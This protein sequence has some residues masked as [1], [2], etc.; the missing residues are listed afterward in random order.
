MKSAFEFGAQR[1]RGRRSERHL[2]LLEKMQHAILQHFGI[3]RKVLELALFQ[4][5]H[6]GVR[7]VADARLQ[8]QQIFGHPAPL[9][10][11]GKKVE[12]MARNQTRSFIRRGELGAAIRFIRLDDGDDFR[13]IAA[14][15]RLADAIA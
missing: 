6:D 3:G 10:L 14:E 7:R 13:W 1:Q 11:V 9:H 15:I 2:A 8:R 4:P 5:R 12:D